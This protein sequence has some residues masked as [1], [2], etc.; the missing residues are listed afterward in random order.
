MMTPFRH[1]RHDLSG[2]Y[3][4][5]AIADPAERSEFERHLLRCKECATEVRGMSETAARLAFAASRLAPPQ[6]RD[7]VLGAVSRTRQLPPNVHDHSSL[8]RPGLAPRPRLGWVAAAACLVVA[9]GLAFA[10]LN[11]E[12]Q[13]Q[14]SKSRAAA[15]SRVLTAPDARAVTKHTSKGGTATVVFSLA[16]HSML[17][18]TAKLPPLPAGKVYQLWLI[19]P[20]HTRSAGLLPAA[21]HGASPPVVVSGVLGGDAFGMTIEPAGGTKQPT[22]TPIVI[23][24]FVR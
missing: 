10:L 17:V 3:A 16:R 14:Q 12:R 20:P 11:A 22:T 18:T 13:L 21:Q 5:D 23:L 7:R 1:D 19:G 2:V 4:L 24:H 15:I 6:L 8:G 9:I